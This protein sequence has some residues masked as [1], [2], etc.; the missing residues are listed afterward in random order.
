MRTAWLLALGLFSLSVSAA[1]SNIAFSIHSAGNGNWSDPATWAE[2]RIPAAND[3][4][5][6]QRGHS[7]TYDV[8]AGTPAADSAIRT[9]HVAG[10]LRFSREKSTQLTVGLIKITPGQTCSEDGFVCHAPAMAVSAPTPETSSAESPALEIGTASD[11][12][13]A[14]V[15]ATIR[16]AYFAG[17]DKETLPAIIACGGRWDVHGAPLSRTW[18]KLGTVRTLRLRMLRSYPAMER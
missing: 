13:P 1:E 10:T 16:L 8:A 11:P 2:K 15:T 3:T 12:M 18:V 7:V 6:I 9:I 14:N 4:V 5:Q 17:M